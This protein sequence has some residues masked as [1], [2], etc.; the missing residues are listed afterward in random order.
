MG[1]F[2]LKDAR[3]NRLQMVIRMLKSQGL[4]LGLI[5]ETKIPVAKPTHTRKYKGYEVYATYTTHI[6]QGGVAFIFDPNTKNWCLQS[7]VRPDPDVLTC[8]LVS[9]DQCTLLIGAYLPPNSIADLAYLEEALQRYPKYTPILMGDLNIDLSKTNHRAQEITNLLSMYGHIDLL[10]HFKHRENHSL[11]TYYQTQKNSSTKQKE[12]V[13]SRCDYILSTDRCLF[14][15]VAIREPRLFTSDHRLVI[16]KYLV[17]PT[18]YH[19]Q[20]L[21][22]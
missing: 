17:R 22:S 13:S 7:F 9:G 19:R 3:N 11:H 18:E 10:P 1:T 12:A 4:H 21:N 16:A 15:N 2:N 5:T 6:N 8:V 20:Y 14:S